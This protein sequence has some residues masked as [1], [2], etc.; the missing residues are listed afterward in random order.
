MQIGHVV[1][2][3]MSDGKLN[4]GTII[5]FTKNSAGEDIAL[6]N[7]FTGEKTSVKID[8]LIKVPHQRATPTIKYIKKVQKEVSEA[9]A[10]NSENNQKRQFTELNDKYCGA[11]AELNQAKKLISK[12]E[13]K[14]AR[15]GD[16]YHALEA[17]LDECQVAR[18]KSSATDEIRTYLVKELLDAVRAKSDDDLVQ[19]LTDIIEHIAKV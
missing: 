12:L 8:K 10:Q 14:L 16:E 18:H 1:K 17:R 2:F 9:N 15:S 3:T 13:E 5:Q 7:T 11:V 6:I 4:G 19:K